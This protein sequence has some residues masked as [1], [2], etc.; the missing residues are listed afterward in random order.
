MRNPFTAKDM[1]SNPGLKVLGLLLALMLWFHVATNRDYETVVEYTL[2]FTGLPD[3][4]VFLGEPPTIARVR[5]QGSGKQLLRTLW[6]NRRWPVDL[7]EAGIGSVRINLGPSDVPLFGIEGVQITELT[8]PR[9]VNLALDILEQ[10]TVPLYSETVWSTAVGYVRVGSEDWTPG[11]VVLRGPRTALANISR[12]RSKRV[13]FLNQSES[14]DQDIDLISPGHYGIT[15]S[16]AQARLRQT[17]EPI[18]TR[19]FAALDVRV[20]ITTHRDTCYVQ[21]PQ[22]DI[23][24]A[25]PESAMNEIILDSIQIVCAVGD[26]DT[27]GTRRSLWV[28]VPEP[29]QVLKAQPDSVTVWREPRP[30]T[31]PRN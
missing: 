31:N 5:A 12:V 7:S 1:L 2:E 30:R 29:L 16:P 25:G 27:S 9:Q 24:V 21:P 14:V 19:D 28:H 3:S 22:V 8:S 20:A 18:I 15:V 10:K 17:V 23:S 6:Q 11:E 13:D 4:V 26:Q